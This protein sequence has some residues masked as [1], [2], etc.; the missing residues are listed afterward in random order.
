M[1]KFTGAPCFA[2]GASVKWTLEIHRVTTIFPV[3]NQI[4]VLRRRNVLATTGN[5]N[6][7]AKESFLP[8]VDKRPF[9]VT[10]LVTDSRIFMSKAYL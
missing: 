3:E 8:D 4:P 5:A 2:L 7:R 9:A 10:S 1:A 6:H